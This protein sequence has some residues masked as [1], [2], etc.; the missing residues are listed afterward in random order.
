[1]TTW[2][3]RDIPPLTGVNAL[4]TG[5]SSGIG[6]PTALELA[7]R[8]A[9]VLLAVRD[10]ARG[11][12]T[13]DRIRDLVPGADVEHGR[14]DLADLRSV[15]EF[16]GTVTGPLDLLVN[17]AGLGMVRRGTT[18]DG[19]ET[20]F[21]VNHL[22]HFALTGLLLPRL[23]ARGEGRPTARVVTVS[24]DAHAWGRIDFDDLALERRYGRFSAYGRSKLANLMFARELQRRAD[25]AGAGL[26]SLAAHPGAT[27]TPFV[28]AGPLTGAL[29]AV[30]RLMMRSPEEG[31]V[32]SL[33][34]ATSPD[35][36]GGEFI[37]PGPKRLTPS[38]KAY[39]EGVARRLWEVSCELTGV[40]FAQ[41]G[42]HATHG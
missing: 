19:F 31:A 9:R 42:R 4:V 2:T 6:V 1:M 28:K 11:R 39:D 14:L 17:N 3:V 21:G 10:P 16:A 23:L 33:Y 7:R 15:R 8:G 38:A 34:A 20:Q 13:A 29:V 35:A 24:S 18:A 25:E 5:A 12:A 36:R 30:A 32:P 27:A 40:D 37:G 41:F 22:G 26:L